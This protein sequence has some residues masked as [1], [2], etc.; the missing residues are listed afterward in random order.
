MPRVLPQRLGGSARWRARFFLKV[1]L[2]RL[3]KRHTTLG[4]KRL[5]YAAK[6]WSAISASVM[7]GLVSTRATSSAACASIGAERRSPP[8]GRAAWL[9]VVF[10]WR[11]NS[12]AV[13]GATPKRSAAPRQLMP[14]N[15]T[16]RMMRTRRS[17]ERG[18]VMRG[19]PPSPA[20]SVNHDLPFK[21][22]PQIDS[23]R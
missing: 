13:D 18:F 10:H 2:R 1:M 8:C 11:S 20:P 19:W 7:S 22:N 5:P 12:T 3:K 23:A 9:P 17:G 4:T 16:A 14:S 21:G 15:S 6:R